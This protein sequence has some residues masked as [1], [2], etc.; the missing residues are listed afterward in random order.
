MG[1]QGLLVSVQPVEMLGQQRKS[2]L[3]VSASTHRATTS[4]MSVTWSGMAQKLH[5][6]LKF[7]SAIK[8]PH[9]LGAV[10][11]EQMPGHQT[12]PRPLCGAPVHRPKAYKAIRRAPLPRRTPKV[13]TSFSSRQRR[14]PIRAGAIAKSAAVARAASYARFS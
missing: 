8:G 3:M 14:R 4:V 9:V 13:S 11:E 5:R 6:H 10:T 1:E 7:E 12:Q 2:S